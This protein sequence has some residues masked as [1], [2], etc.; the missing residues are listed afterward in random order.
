MLNPIEN[1]QG[2]QVS[3][4]QADPINAF[5]FGF[6]CVSDLLA[7]S[8][9]TELL[10]FSVTPFK[11]DQNKNQNNSIDKVQILREERR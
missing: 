8:Q 2:H 5:H 6:S 9:Q 1:Y 4:N 11:I 3:N 7:I 10:V